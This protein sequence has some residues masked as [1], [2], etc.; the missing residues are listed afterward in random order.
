MKVRKY[1]KNKSVKDVEAKNVRNKKHYGFPVFKPRR[2][3]IFVDTIDNE[4]RKNIKH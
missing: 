3:G 2:G 1:F 4:K